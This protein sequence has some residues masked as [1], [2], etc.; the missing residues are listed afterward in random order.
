MKINPLTIPKDIMFLAKIFL[1]M[2]HFN[3]FIKSKKHLT[4][5]ALKLFNADLFKF[6][7]QNK[8]LCSF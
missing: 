8:K 4:L 6:L 1:K 7:L 3:E 5:R 2:E